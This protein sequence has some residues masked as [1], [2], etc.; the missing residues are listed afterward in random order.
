[1]SGAEASRTTESLRVVHF[2]RAP[3]GGVL[4]HVCDLARGQHEGGYKVG[5][6]M[7][8]APSDPVSIGRLRD[9]EAVCELGIHVVPMD[10]MPGL[11][12][13]ANL[14]RLRRLVRSLGADIVHGHGAKGGAYARLL[15]RRAGGLRIYTPHGGALHFDPQSMKGRLFFMAERLMRLRTDGFIFESEFGLRTFGRLVGEPLAPAA[16]VHNGISGSDCVPVTPRADAADFVFIGELRALKGVGTLI[17]AL[18]L[19]GRSAH[20]RIVG[21]GAER[22]AFERMAGQAPANVRIEFMGPLP[23]REAFASGRVVV[24]PSHHESLP[25][26]ALEAAAAGLPLIATRVGGIPEIF[27]AD[28]VRLVEPADATAL[29]A[30]LAHALDDPDDMTAFAMRLRE[31]VCAEFS[32]ARMI[33]GVSGFY[34]AARE[35]A[36]KPHRGAKER[37]RIAGFPEGISS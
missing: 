33:E 34:R 21:S 13:V 37:V 1:M 2:L 3:L 5:M 28:S 11:G 20:L 4:R 12:D 31:R 32:V 35:Q 30:A 17:E 26:V 36:S 27:G 19:L 9:A 25:Y 10:R 14:L 29:S 18:H 16:V 22:E 23:A 7:G 15:S 6:V 24:L 8:E